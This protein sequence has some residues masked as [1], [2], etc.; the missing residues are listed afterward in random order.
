MKHYY[1]KRAQ[2]EEL[3]GPLRKKFP[4]RSP[5][6]YF[7]PYGRSTLTILGFLKV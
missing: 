2:N 5:H 4:K 1:Q 7:E 3:N 6:V